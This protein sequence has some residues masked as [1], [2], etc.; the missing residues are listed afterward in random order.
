MLRK[1]K[2]AMTKEQRRH[3]AVQVSKK[4]VKYK[5]LKI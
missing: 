5:G 3:Q 1:H 4:N 2:N